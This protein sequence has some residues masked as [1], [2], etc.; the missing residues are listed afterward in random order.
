M[1]GTF[2]P[3]PRVSDSDINHGT[4][5]T[6]VSWCMPGSLTSDFLWNRRRGKTFPA[7]LA[8][9]QSAFYVSGKRPIATDWQT[10]AGCKNTASVRC[11]RQGRGTIALHYLPKF[12]ILASMFVCRFVCLSVCLSVCPSVCLSVS[13]SVLSSMNALTYHHQ[14]WSTY[15]LGH[16]F[17]Y[18]TWT[19]SRSQN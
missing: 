10:D 5:V 4:C 12:T 17:L 11:V 7:F 8:H 15:V 14:T 9:A 1:P 13:L 16:W 3:P 2:S 6:H 18:V 19:K